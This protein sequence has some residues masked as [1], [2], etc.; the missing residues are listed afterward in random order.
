MRRV[1]LVLCVASALLVPAASGTAQ[2]GDPG[3][4]LIM[5]VLFSLYHR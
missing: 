3:V 1:L 2:E 5:A 4:L